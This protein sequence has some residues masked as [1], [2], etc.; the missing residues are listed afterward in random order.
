MEI[1]RSQ[2]SPS[3]CQQPRQTTHFSSYFRGRLGR[4]WVAIRPWSLTRVYLYVNTYIYISIHNIIY[5]H[6]YVHYYPFNQS[7]FRHWC[8]PS[9]SWYWINV[10]VPCYRSP[11]PNASLGKEEVLQAHLAKHEKAGNFKL[12]T[13]KCIQPRDTLIFSNKSCHLSIDWFQHTP[14]NWVKI[15]S[16]C[17]LGGVST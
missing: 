13:V 6:T 14:K 11:Y 8:K 7:V 5:I 1:Y 9:K 12:T 4:P 15:D 2:P 17:L 16:H 3:I 10:S